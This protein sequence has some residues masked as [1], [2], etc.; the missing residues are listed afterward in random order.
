MQAAKFPSDC[1]GFTQQCLVF[2]SF[3]RLAGWN[4]ILR[5]AY[6]QLGGLYFC[7]AAYCSI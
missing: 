6:G 2:A 1:V 4:F 3:S 7:T 5:Q